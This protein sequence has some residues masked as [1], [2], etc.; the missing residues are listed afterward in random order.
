MACGLAAAAGAVLIMASMD[1]LL[2][3]RQSPDTKVLLFPPVRRE[4]KRELRSRRHM[5]AG[6]LQQP[7]GAGAFSYPVVTCTC[8]SSR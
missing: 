4:E 1:V 5:T 6:A 8:R 2:R 3:P 7:R